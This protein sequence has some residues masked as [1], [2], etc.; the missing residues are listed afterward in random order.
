MVDRLTKGGL[1]PPT[2]HLNNSYIKNTNNGV[3]TMANFILK[4]T[5]F[6]QSLLI[7]FLLGKFT[8]GISPDS[9]GMGIF[10]PNL[11]GYHYSLINDE[12]SGFYN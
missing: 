11:G 3:E 2:N 1:T 10:V 8:Y 12:D 6:V 7:A 5:F 4:T 9:D